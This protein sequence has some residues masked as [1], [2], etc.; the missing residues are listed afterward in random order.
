MSD[1]D[2]VPPSKM[3]GRSNRQVS[4]QNAQF[5]AI[6]PRPNLLKSIAVSLLLHLPIPKLSLLKEADISLQRAS[7][8]STVRFHCATHHNSL[9]LIPRSKGPSPASSDTTPSRTKVTKLH[10]SKKPYDRP[11]LKIH[12][13][14]KPS[15]DFTGHSDGDKPLVPRLNEPRAPTQAPLPGDWARQAPLGSAYHL[16]PE[17]MPHAAPLAPHAG[18][19]AGLSPAN[20]SLVPPGGTQW[21]PWPPAWIQ[22]QAVPL[23]MVGRPYDSN[24]MYPQ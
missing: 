13:R 22:N 12:P 15:L 14:S 8:K 23:P 20:D 7:Q 3:D 9:I 1:I 4:S 6:G 5:L 11:S 16:P 17:T 10:R 24:S 21:H 2:E 18:Y 19:N